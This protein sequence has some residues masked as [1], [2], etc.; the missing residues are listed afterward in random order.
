MV[1][2][3][4][5]LLSAFA[6]GC[7]C[8]AVLVALGRTEDR[9]ADVPAPRG[10]TVQSH[11]VT[12][13]P[14]RAATPDPTHVASLEPSTTSAAK[15]QREPAPRADDVAE[16]SPPGDSVADVLARLEAGYRERL[17]AKEPPTDVATSAVPA[18][19]APAPTAAPV[20]LAA[21]RP[22][23]GT[24]AAAPAPTAL[25]AVPVATA[26]AAAPPSVAADAAQ[27]KDHDARERERDLY[28]ASLYRAEAY[29]RQQLVVLQYLELLSQSRALPPESSPR[30]PRSLATRRSPSFSFPLTNPDN[31]WGF[32]LPPTVLVK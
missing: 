13:P 26:A 8:T 4:L 15:P 29:Q 22:Q 5:P 12:A 28:L 23:D 6:G 3:R 24:P 32:D 20:T 17:I 2:A 27:V 21:G 9:E 31:P 14:S 25:A 16:A 30:A 1:A 7:L 18:V 11:D 10:G 19:T